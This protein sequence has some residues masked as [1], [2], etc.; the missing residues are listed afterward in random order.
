M[1]NTENKINKLNQNNENDST[2]TSVL[3]NG[4]LNFLGGTTTI[5]AGGACNSVYISTLSLFFSS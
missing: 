3:I 5:C 4:L 2:I 1:K